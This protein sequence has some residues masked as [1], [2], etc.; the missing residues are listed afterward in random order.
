[1]KKQGNLIFGTR[2]VMEAIHAGKDVD[3]I[4]LQKNLRNDLT[5]ELILLARDH[6][7]P[8]SQVPQEKLDRLTKKN[9]QGTLCFL[10]AVSYASFDH[11]ISETFSKGE[12][13][14]L[15]ILDRV[16]DVRN[17]G[18]IVRSADGAGVHAIIIP[19]KGNAPTNPDAIKTSAGALHHVPV[20]REDNLKQAI[21]FLKDSGIKI[22]ACTEKA[23]KFYYD[24]NLK[25]PVAL[26]LGS[27]EDGISP[28]Y[29]RMCD[30]QVKIPMLGKIASL[31]VSVS[32]GLLLYETVRQR[33]AG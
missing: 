28:E 26:L 24:E 19:S 8:V 13:P 14:F 4:F 11:I 32:A 12:A 30:S 15:V 33:M 9:H 20:C 18:A 6:H 5:K 16:T 3:R 25:D 7:I 23:E 27:E 29:L 31:N 1:V 2:A 21:T 17:F 22:V 10:S